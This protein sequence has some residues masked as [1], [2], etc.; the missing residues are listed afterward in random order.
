[1][2]RLILASTICAALTGCADKTETECDSALNVE[3]YAR[4][5]SGSNVLV[6]EFGM[7]VMS[8][9]QPYEHVS[10]PVH[11]TYN[12]SAWTFPEIWLNDNASIYAFY[13]YQSTSDMTFMNLSLHQQT[14]YLY[15]PS[16]IA[17]DKYNNTVHITMDHLL[18]KIKVRVG[19]SEAISFK[20]K[21]IETT[22]TYNL[23]TNTLTAANT[24]TVESEGSEALIFPAREKTLRMDI[25]HAG[26]NYSYTA[27]SKSYEGG[28]EYTYNLKIS[29]SKE[30]VIDGEVVVTPWKSGGE[31]DGT[32]RE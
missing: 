32:V 29:D 7:Y 26:K 22:A 1:M 15:T 21:D 4:S 3:C 6:K 24:G 30:L 9:D 25:I 31:Y 11:V 28:K 10:N 27:P 17:A 23:R 18:S 14:D 12:G 19:G 8:G 13:P 20:I 2:K 5:T 16:P